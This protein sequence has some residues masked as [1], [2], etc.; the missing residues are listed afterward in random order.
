ML[1]VLKK[2][3]QYDSQKDNANEKVTNKEVILLNDNLFN[4]WYI[5]FLRVMLQFGTFLTKTTMT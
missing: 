1:T 3:D 4:I 5:L 2:N